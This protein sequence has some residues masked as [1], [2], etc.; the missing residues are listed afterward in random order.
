MKNQEIQ[1]MKELAETYTA[2]LV[3]FREGDIIEAEV[4]AVYS[5]QVLINIDGLYLGVVPEIELSVNYKE[6]NPGDKT[7]VYI[8][9]MQNDKGQAILSLRRADRER[10]TRVLQESYRDDKAR[11]VPVKIKEANRGGLIVTYGE[12]EG[13]LPV[14]QLNP[15]HYPRVGSDNKDEIQNRLS[16][17]I[18]QTLNAKVITF[19]PQMN[20]IIFS[21]KLV[22][23]DRQ[24]EI[25]KKYKVGQQLKGKISGIVDFGVFVDLG[26]IE[27]LIHISELSWDRVDD[28]N[29]LFKVGN[30][31]KVEII[32]ID[33]GKIS[34]SVKRLQEDPWTQKIKK[35]K[36]G[37]KVKGKI[38]RITP[39]G[40][41]VMIN[42]IIEGLIHVSEIIDK[43]EKKVIDPGKI[44]ETGKEYPF[45]VLSIEPKTHRFSLAMRK[46][47]NEKSKKEETQT[48]KKKRIVKAIKTKTPSI[49]SKIK[50]Q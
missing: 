3:P 13:F 49:K 30:S 20:K 31:V 38:T 34:L 44:F 40:A 50:K 46:P 1:T 43:E 32:S 41:F 15:E 39:F 11:A 29:K 18:G 36:T 28:I 9:F 48:V 45:Y 22:V 12:I 27:G 19:E 25:L 4:M 2:S 35:F 16:R 42:D 14:S 6:L 21:E 7:L 17:L 24:A 23:N 33:H 37:Q 5:N 47:Q 26:D 10:I 8:L